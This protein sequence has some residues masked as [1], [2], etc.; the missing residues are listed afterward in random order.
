MEINQGGGSRLLGRYVERCA[1]VGACG[2]GPSGLLLAAP[3]SRAHKWG[4]ALEVI[5][6]APGRNP[7][8]LGVDEK[9]LP[10]SP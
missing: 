6:F 7:R 4:L 3:K 8:P 1:G 2:R 5:H 9:P 10:A